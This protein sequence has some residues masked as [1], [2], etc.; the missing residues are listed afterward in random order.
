MQWTGYPNPPS[1]RPAFV[2]KIRS[3]KHE[4]IPELGTKYLAGLE[5]ALFMCKHMRR[6]ASV[7]NVIFLSDGRPGDLNLGSRSVPSML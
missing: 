4:C 7:Q 2:N 1:M 5:G 3:I 6:R